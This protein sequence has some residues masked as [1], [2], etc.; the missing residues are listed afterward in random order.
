MGEEIKEQE[1]IFPRAL[2]ITPKGERV[3]DF[4]Q[5]MTGYVSL[6]IKGKKGER[7]K[8]SFAEVLDGDGNF[9]NSMDVIRDI[10]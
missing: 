6:K 4:G 7:V 9:Y 8:L 2:I 1:S 3:I 5:N 10:R